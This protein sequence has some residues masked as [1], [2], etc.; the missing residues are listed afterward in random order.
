M[1]NDHEVLV[2]ERWS[3]AAALCMLPIY[4]L[5]LPYVLQS[6]GLDVY[7]IN[8]VYF[9]VGILLAGLLF[10]PFLRRSFPRFLTGKERVTR[11][12]A[13]GAIG[14]YAGAY[15]LSAA[16]LF[17]GVLPQTQ[18]N[19]SIQALTR[20]AP[21][22]MFLFAVIAAP[23]TEECLFRGALFGTLRTKHRV[24][25]YLV[26]AFTFA[27]IHAAPGVA[28]GSWTDLYAALP[29]LAPGIALCYAYE[30]SGTI[31]T[32]IVLHA[33]INAVSFVLV[34]LSR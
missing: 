15:I 30:Y 14:H 3:T 24:A 17:S 10:F 26:T 31:W 33:A 2:P 21:V 7:L 8:Y 19:Q 25:A 27:A 20:H 16:L 12:L 11:A 28:A 32:S 1:P 13:A 4:Y 9:A 5:C 29:Y 34:L 18:N 23:I 22:L 6:F